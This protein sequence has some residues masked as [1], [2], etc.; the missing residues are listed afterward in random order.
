MI[1]YSQNLRA[2]AQAILGSIIQTNLSINFVL[3][4]LSMPRNFV[5]F[6][7]KGKVIEKFRDNDTSYRFKVKTKSGHTLLNSIAFTQKEDVDKVVQQ[8]QTIKISN[9]YFE[10]KTD[11]EG[12]F[13]FNLKDA[14]GNLIGHSQLYDS[15]MGMENGI[16]NLQNQIATLAQASES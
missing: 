7:E 16:K 14:N 6:T 11:H 15:E 2:F 1:N 10:R 9:N 12:H 4:Q 13:L 8:L 3:L 5:S